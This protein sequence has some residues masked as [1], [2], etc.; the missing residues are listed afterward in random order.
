MNIL[1]VTQY[2]HRFDHLCF[3]YYLLLIVY[4]LIYNLL[5]F[6]YNL[7]LQFLFTFDT[8]VYIFI[9]HIIFFFLVCP[10]KL[11]IAFAV[12]QNMDESEFAVTK[13][14]LK[15]A[16]D[17]FDVKP[18]KAHIAV[19]TFGREAKLAFDFNNGQESNENVRQK[20]D[21]L[22]Y[23]YG[24]GRLTDILA[25]SCDAVFCATGGTRDNMPKVT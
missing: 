18:D 6:S 11:D 8:Y 10:R 17:R 1:T 2:S 23:E 12:H 21:N 19:M 9:D 4:S 13:Y 14:F 22:E 24:I 3:S 20:V 25:L 5:S 15:S 7:P 16:I